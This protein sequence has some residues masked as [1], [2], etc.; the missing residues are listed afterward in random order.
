MK[1]SEAEKIITE[2]KKDLGTRMVILGHHYQS[3]EVLEFADYIG[4]SL[5]LARKAST[6]TDADM[7]VFCGVYFMAETASIL[8]PGKSVYIPD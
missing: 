3:D 2:V 7:I 5:E 6:I 1:N 8:A 4:D